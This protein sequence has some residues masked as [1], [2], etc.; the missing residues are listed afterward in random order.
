MK[1][2]KIIIGIVVVLIAAVVIMGLIAP[3]E[4][5]VSRTITIDAPRD[6]TF[7]HVNSLADMNQWSPWMELDPNMSDSIEGEDGAVGAIHHWSGNEDVGKGSQEI[8]AITEDRIDTKVRFLEPFES[9]ADASV[10][11]TGDDKTSQVTWTFHGDSPFPMNAMNLF[12]DM[13]KMLG[14]D[15]EKGLN[16]LKTLVETEKTKRAEFG[17]YT[18]EV[19]ELTPRTYIGIRDTVAWSDMG[20]YYATNLGKAHGAVAKAK[21]EMAGA[22]SGVYFMWD[23]QGQRAEMLAGVPV[24]GEQAV[25]KFDSFSFGGKVLVINYYGPYEGSGKAH[26]AMDEYIKWHGLTQN[27]PVIEEYITDPQSE[28]D[29][30]KWLTKVYY[31]VE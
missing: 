9:E 15:Y 11:V 10:T 20:T 22:P 4:T 14:P 12:M 8:I 21:L 1:A 16:S 3:R 18:I 23:E 2:V 31:P 28:P 5:E 30:A 19:G 17:G 29:Q 26:E 24:S 6:F 7:E 25:D 13:D 27:G